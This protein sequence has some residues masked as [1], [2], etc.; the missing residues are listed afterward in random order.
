MLVG[1]AMRR[2]SGAGRMS[3]ASSCLAPR[4]LIYRSRRQSARRECAAS[5]SGSIVI[6]VIYVTQVAQ[7][8]AAAASVGRCAHT[9]G[10]PGVGGVE[11]REGIPLS[12]FPEDPPRALV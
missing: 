5:P 2:S 9:L 11:P 3:A 4:D 10:L 6:S 1:N 12:R 8:S 7:E